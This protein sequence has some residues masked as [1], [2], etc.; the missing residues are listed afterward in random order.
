V[1]MRARTI[2]ILLLVCSVLS[3]KRKKTNWD[4]DFILPIAYA[5]L[6][7]ANF[8]TDSILSN[9]TNGTIR[10]VYNGQF[11][12]LASDIVKIPDTSLKFYYQNLLGNVTLP[13]GT[14]LPGFSYPVNFD[15][16]G[17][18]LKKARL[19]QGEIVVNAKNYSRVPIKITLSIP[20]AQ[21]NG[22]P[23]LESKVISG[24][25]NGIPGVVGASFTLS[26]YDLNLFNA[27]TNQ[28]N[29]LNQSLT[30]TTDGNSPN[31]T[32]FFL[33]SVAVEI[34][35]RNFVP[36]YV[37]GYFGKLEQNFSIGPTVFDFKSVLN[38]DQ[39]QIQ[40][41]ILDLEFKNFVGADLR[42]DIYNFTGI[43]SING[44]SK[45]LR[46][47]NNAPIRFNVTKSQSNSVTYDTIFPSITQYSF[48]ANNSNIVDFL[49][50]VPDNVSLNGRFTINPL[51]INLNNFG[52]FYK[53]DK[54]IDTKYKITIPGK[55]SFKNLKVQLDG[56]IDIGN[57]ENLET[58]KEGELIL[59]SA[60]YFP[61]D[62]QLQGY[63]LNDQNQV[64]DSLINKA[65]SINA[66]NINGNLN[67][68]TKNVNNILLDQKQKDL[69]KNYK[70]IRWVAVINTKD[71]NLFELRTDYTLDLKLVARALVNFSYD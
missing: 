34:K 4:S 60:N 57:E 58:F 10:F 70:K 16:K 28:F 6:K 27:A 44:I 22:Q 54:L 32:I 35:F 24:K 38:A 7:P 45:N 30:F 5:S 29:S 9:D 2:F 26:N 25:S 62:I 71:N 49:N 18:K 15:L 63:Y 39:I 61:Y 56:E 69:L 31:D 42:A 47:S 48:N 36:D 52:D 51:G 43:N 59:Y 46:L 33:D 12:N 67:T 21:L 13:P 8:I 64:V 23:F 17:I 41:A 50:N 19:N 66:S 37:N 14:P 1:V 11:T 20:N 3:C 65:F 53:K 40:N 68:P 55:F